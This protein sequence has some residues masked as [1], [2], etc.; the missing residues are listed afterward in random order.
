MSKSFKVSDTTCT[1]DKSIYNYWYCALYIHLFIHYTN[2]KVQYLHFKMQ[3]SGAEKCANFCHSWINILTV[4]LDRDFMQCS[5]CSLR[6]P[7]PFSASSCHLHFSEGV[8]SGFIRAWLRV[9]LL[10]AEA[11]H[12]LPWL[13]TRR[14]G[15]C[16]GD[17]ADHHGEGV[18][19]VCEW[20]AD[21]EI[22]HYQQNQPTWRWE[23]V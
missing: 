6:W 19:D 13:S 9:L 4:L 1:S 10:P 23:D 20:G 22:C 8:Y 18:C 5:S 11:E 17:P 12:H 2:V 3:W 15:P 7:F 16:T 21:P 14:P